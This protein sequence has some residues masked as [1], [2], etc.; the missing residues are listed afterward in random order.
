MNNVAPKSTSGNDHVEN[1]E[2]KSGI[3]VLNPSQVL[4]NDGDHADSLFIIQKGQLRL[5][6]PKGK[7][8]VE[9]SVLRAGE[10]IGEM[11]YFSA[12]DGENKRSCSAQAMTRTEI[13][14]ISFK[15]FEKTLNNLNPWFKTIIN[16]LASRLRKTNLKL[17]ELESNSVTTG[18]GKNVGEYKFFSNVDIIRLLTV[19][20]LAIKAHG[21]VRGDAIYI[22]RKTLKFYA[23]DIFNILDVKFEEFIGL[24][25]Q[26]GLLKIELDPDKLPNIFIFEKSETFRAIFLFINTQRNVADDKKIKITDKCEMILEKILSFLYE[27]NHDAQRVDVELDPFFKEFQSQNITVEVDDLLPAKQIRL[28]GD[29]LVNNGKMSCWVDYQELKK[30]FTQIKFTNAINRVNERKSKLK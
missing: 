9:L 22:N 11:A 30:I 10:V 12:D 24:I 2:K 27:Q 23:I 7:G 1:R 16:S 28:V 29:V 15:A 21:E 25:K 19:F 13:I 20:Y 3:I 5:F 4:F 6:K 17:K 8:Y 14:E 18:Y 26:Q